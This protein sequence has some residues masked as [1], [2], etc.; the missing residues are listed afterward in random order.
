MT[1]N[2]N[3]H[4]ILTDQNFKTEVLHNPEPVVVDFWAPWCGPCQAMNPIITELASEYEGRVRVGKL[5][6]DEQ[7]DIPAQYDITS[8]PTLLFF[9]HGQIVGRLVGAI[10]KRLLAHKLG[11]L[12][13]TV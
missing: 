1:E 4:L 9:K 11:E 8:I 2:H 5:N 12:L 13:R 6:V 7:P 3:G 10:P